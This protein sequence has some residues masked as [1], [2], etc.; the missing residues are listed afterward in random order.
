MNYQPSI[1]DAPKEYRNTQL[2][3]P[4]LQ[5]AWDK[6]VSVKLPAFFSIHSYDRFLN[7]RFRQAV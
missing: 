2:L 1:S 5:A 6:R 4:M 7:H 3:Y